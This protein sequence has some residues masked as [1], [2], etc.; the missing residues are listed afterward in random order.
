[1]N[2]QSIPTR[3]RIVKTESEGEGYYDWL[4]HT[5]AIRGQQIRLYT[6]PGIAGFRTL[7]PAA[8]LLAENMM[9]QPGAALL[10]LNCGPGL[11]GTVAARLAGEDAVT[12]IDPNC[13]AVAAARRT[14]EINQVQG[15]QILEL[16]HPASL[17][18]EPVD[19]VAIRLPKGK[20]RLKQ[21]L[22]EG[23]RA[24]RPGGRL[25][26]AGGNQ[27]G[28]KT[29][30]AMVA[31]LFGQVAVL[32]YRK[33]FR[34]GSAV[35]ETETPADPTAFTDPWLAPGAFVSFSVWAR[36]QEVQI[37]SRPGVFSWD[38]M[39]GGTARLLEVLRV[40]P[41]DSV[42]DLGCGFG[43]IGVVAAHLA[44]DVKVTLVDAD[45]AAIEAATATLRANHV[46]HGRAVLQDCGAGLATGSFD[47]VATN[48][49]FHQGKKTDYDV[50]RQFVQEA[51]RVL[52]PGGVLYLVANRFLPYEAQ[53]QGAFDNVQQVT[54]DSQY[55]VLIARIGERILP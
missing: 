3:A 29:A 44:P 27:E 25:Y 53:M 16:G 11:V 51:A 13:V 7:D 10:T 6:K 46:Q 30:L 36:G 4:M 38:R 23:F 41:G 54:M 50:G 19:L 31:K 20:P 1:M 45:A 52:K 48:P 55:K 28:I 15:V 33:G 5:V 14:I 37:R 12:L 22:W 34:V 9:V 24:L 47:V 26:L 18:L 8:A 49:P 21:L 39:D 40:Q 32:G 35:K 2:E 43:L 42:L 17:S